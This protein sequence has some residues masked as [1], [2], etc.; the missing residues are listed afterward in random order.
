[1]LNVIVRE[2]CALYTIQLSLLLTSKSL[3]IKSMIEGEGAKV[4]AQ[5]HVTSITNFH[6]KVIT[7][8]PIVG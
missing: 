8:G 2:L 1:M 6:L 7:F 5:I 3:Y 4:K